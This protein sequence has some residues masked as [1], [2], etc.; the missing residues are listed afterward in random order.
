MYC[1]VLNRSPPQLIQEIILVDDYSNDRK[2][3]SEAFSEL[4]SYSRGSGNGG[5][6]G[7]FFYNYFI[8]VLI[9]M[10]YI[11]NFLF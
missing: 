4:F 3:E 7:K 1:S 10:I 2:Y 9:K 11:P 5:G 8:T 6:G